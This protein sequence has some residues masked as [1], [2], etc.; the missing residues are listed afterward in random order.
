MCLNRVNVDISIYGVKSVNILDLIP[1]WNGMSWDSAA[2]SSVWTVTL[3]I[4][5]L[6]CCFL[7]TLERPDVAW[8]LYCDWQDTI[9]VLCFMIGEWMAACFASL[10]C[11][12]FSFPTSYSGWRGVHI[13]I[14]NWDP[15]MNLVMSNNPLT[16]T[17]DLH[18][19]LCKAH[20]F[21]VIFQITVRLHSICV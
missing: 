20:I 14:L 9:T 2:V 18:K 7:K 6:L 3:F 5:H 17:H 4:S 19:G 1:R 15:H 11:C 16:A 12:L 10:L 21:P 13:W 8:L